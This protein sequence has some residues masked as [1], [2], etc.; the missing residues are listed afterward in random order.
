MWKTLI[1]QIQL[2]F[3][4][5]GA[6]LRLHFRLLHAPMH[7]VGVVRAFLFKLWQHNINYFV[8]ILFLLLLLLFNFF[9][10]YLF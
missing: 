9:C 6:R 10:P 3:I 8:C 5:S 1:S 4:K 2:L 7:S